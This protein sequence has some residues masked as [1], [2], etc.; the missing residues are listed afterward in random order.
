MNVH[1]GAAWQVRVH[2]YWA[3]ATRGIIDT[4]IE[5]CVSIIHG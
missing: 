2:A 4:V 3:V 1:L 5:T